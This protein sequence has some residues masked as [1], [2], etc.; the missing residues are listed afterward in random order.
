MS[1][2][3]HEWSKSNAWFPDKERVE[4]VPGREGGC[5]TPISS[6]LWLKTD[7]TLQYLLGPSPGPDDARRPP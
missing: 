2:T 1:V 3:E 7:E 5:A 6:T 4:T